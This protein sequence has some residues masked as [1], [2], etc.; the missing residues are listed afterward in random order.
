MAQIKE[1]IEAES[2]RNGI[3]EMRV[4]RLYR[5]GAFFRAYVFQSG[6]LQI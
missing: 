4:I 3:A 6:F 2:Q 1:I 5:E